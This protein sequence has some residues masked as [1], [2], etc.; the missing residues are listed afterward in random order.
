MSEYW[1]PKYKWQLI[2]WFV[3]NH[4]L[5]RRKANR[6]SKRQLYGKYREVRDGNGGYK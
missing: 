3:S 2:E 6:M 1:I 5:T 4:L